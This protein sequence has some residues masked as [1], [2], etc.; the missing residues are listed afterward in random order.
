MYHFEQ[1]TFLILPGFFHHLLVNSYPIKFICLVANPK[2]YSNRLS[3]IFWISS[4]GTMWRIWIDPS[5][6]LES[7]EV[8]ITSFI[9]RFH[10]MYHR[11]RFFLWRMPLISFLF[12]GDV[13]LKNLSLKPSALDELDLPVKTIYGHLGK[14]ETIALHLTQLNEFRIFFIFPS[15]KTIFD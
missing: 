9:Y 1:L 11:S 8:K 6:K 10:I 4:W 15:F 14:E 7:G 13:S 12:I 5:W 2:W 3:L